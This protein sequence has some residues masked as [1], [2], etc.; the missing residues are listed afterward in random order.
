MVWV[1]LLAPVA[2]ISESFVEKLAIGIVEWWND[3]FIE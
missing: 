2:G 1:H 3:G